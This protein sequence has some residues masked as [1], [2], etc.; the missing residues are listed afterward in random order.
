[1]DEPIRE[2]RCVKRLDYQR[3]PAMSEAEA[4]HDWELITDAAYAAVFDH[5]PT[6]QADNITSVEPFGPSKT[7]FEWRTY[8]HSDDGLETVYAVITEFPRLDHPEHIEC[9]DGCGLAVTHDGP[10]LDRPGGRQVCEHDPA[11]PPC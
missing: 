5:V 6:L 11:V 9:A 1:M 7:G 10:C 2:V 3:D 4:W 8:W